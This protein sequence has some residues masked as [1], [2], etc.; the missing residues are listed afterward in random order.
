VY[1]VKEF[2]LLVE[3]PEA[4]GVVGRNANFGKTR[5]IIMETRTRHATG[6]M[7]D[8]CFHILVSHLS[9]RFTSVRLLTN[10]RLSPRCRLRQ[11]A[12]AVRVQDLLVVKDTTWASQHEYGRSHVG[13]GA[14]TARRVAHA[15]LDTA[16]VVF[17]GSASGHLD[18]VSSSG[19]GS[20]CEVEI[21]V[22]H[23]GRHQAR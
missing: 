10:G 22:P 7:H 23:L 17:V 9:Y 14:R 21:Y 19:P 20:H 5:L 4:F 13:V 12:S 8:D 15:R 6:F 18:S 1:S 11:G 2:A 16:L 3:L